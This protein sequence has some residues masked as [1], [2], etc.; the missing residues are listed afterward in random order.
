MGLSFL[1]TAVVGSECGLLWC[2]KDL[3]L[4]LSWHFKETFSQVTDFIVNFK[5]SYNQ[6]YCLFTLLI[7]VVA[8][9]LCLTILY[10]LH[11]QVEQISSIPFFL[12]VCVCLRVCLHI[13]GMHVEAPRLCC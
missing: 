10:V 12:S 11:N 8:Y 6:F 13:C 4:L 3:T 2:S 5:L 9:I 7:S 1:L